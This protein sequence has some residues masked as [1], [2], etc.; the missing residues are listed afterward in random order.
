[1]AGILVQPAEQPLFNEKVELLDGEGKTVKTIEDVSSFHNAPYFDT[2]ILGVEFKYLSRYIPERV[3]RSHIE[4]TATFRSRKNDDILI[5]T[6]DR[7]FVFTEKEY[8]EFVADMGKYRYYGVS[9]KRRNVLGGYSKKRKYPDGISWIKFISRLSED[10]STSCG[11]KSIAEEEFEELPPEY[12]GFRF[13]TS[14][15]FEAHL[16]DHVALNEGYV[17]VPGLGR[18]TISKISFMIP[19][20]DSFMI[21]KVN[22]D[23]F[24]EIPTESN[25]ALLVRAEIDEAVGDSE[26][27]EPEDFEL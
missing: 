22:Y 11:Y 1:M 26:V 8:D 14:A 21:M 17:L 15:V 25:N 18:K 2:R 3:I 16:K 9:E 20:C 10:D 12:K 24:N 6:I 19:S 13:S 4:F 5:E 27:S 23:K 7:E